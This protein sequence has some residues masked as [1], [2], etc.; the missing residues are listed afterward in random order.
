MRS[1]TEETGRRSMR[2][3]VGHSE[4][5]ESE[6]ENGKKEEIPI[7]SPNHQAAQQ[8]RQEL[9]LRETR[10]IWFLRLVF[11]F[12]FLLLAVAAGITT[13]VWVKH[14]EQSAFETEFAF[15]AEKV[16]R[17][18]NAGFE[19]KL[20]AIDALS[21]GI[22]SYAMQ[23]SSSFP[24]VSEFCLACKQLSILLATHLCAPGCYF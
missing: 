9:G 18:F 7:V 19:R 8:A 11:V 1:H 13:Y 2:G 21:T 23:S 16:I 4:L 24:N 20:G 14:N 3:Q 5:D 12:V 22:T 10:V 15:Y 17:M 6:S